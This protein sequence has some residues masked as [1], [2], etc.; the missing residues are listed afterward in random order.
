MTAAV[1]ED[2]VENTIPVFVQCQL[3]SA[4]FEIILEFVKKSW[5]D[6]TGQYW[7]YVECYDSYYIQQMYMSYFCMCFSYILHEPLHCDILFIQNG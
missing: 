7:M 1:G 4:V 5:N 2:V 3:T 6:E